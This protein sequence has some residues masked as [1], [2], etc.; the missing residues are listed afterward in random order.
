M[1]C[2]ILRCASPP[3]QADTLITPNTPLDAIPT[4]PELAPLFEPTQVGA[5][6]LAMRV[7]YAPLTRCRALGTVPATATAQYYSGAASISAFQPGAV[8][9]L[10]NCYSFLH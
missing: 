10:P 4:P 8:S 7:V 6:E 3:A 9:V 1:P 5:F 2:R